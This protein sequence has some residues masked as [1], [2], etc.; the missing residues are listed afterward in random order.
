MLCNIWQH[1]QVIKNRSSVPADTV[2]L[3]PIQLQHISIQV[4]SHLFAFSSVGPW[5]VALSNLEI[6][7]VGPWVFVH[8]ATQVPYQSK[9]IDL[10][11]YLIK[12]IIIDYC[13]DLFISHIDDVIM[14]KNSLFLTVTGLEGLWMHFDTRFNSLL[15]L[16]LSCWVSKNLELRYFVY[17]RPQY[18]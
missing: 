5:V 11:K 18:A 4:F 1:Y 2:L 10:I 7:R 6:A 16:C 13:K 15:W 12:A 3:Q 8:S 9:I 17:W 14:C